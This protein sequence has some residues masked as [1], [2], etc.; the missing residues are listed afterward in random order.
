MKT[1]KVMGIIGIILSGLCYLFIAF[2]MDTN[3]QGA[4]GWGVIGILY[5]LALS[6]IGVVQANR[7]KK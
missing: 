7:N 2:L 4:I 6:I 5:L 1:L 3:P